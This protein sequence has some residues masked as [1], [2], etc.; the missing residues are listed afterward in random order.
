MTRTKDVCIS[1]LFF[2]Q[3][4]PYSPS[5]GFFFFSSFPSFSS[6]DNAY[7][8]SEIRAVASTANSIEWEDLVRA[9]GK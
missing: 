1:T 2:P 5:L 3:N 8:I 4:T 6:L 7:G 9:V